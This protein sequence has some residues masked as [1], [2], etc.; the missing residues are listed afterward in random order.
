MP[1]LNLGSFCTRALRLK[2]DGIALEEVFM[3]RGIPK[4]S[5]WSRLVSSEHGDAR[6]GMRRHKKILQSGSLLPDPTR[7]TG[8]TLR[9]RAQKHTQQI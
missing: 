7:T 1:H 4:R 8:I 6:W 9:A 3:L 5:K 2:S